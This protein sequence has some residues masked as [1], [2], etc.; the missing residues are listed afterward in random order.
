LIC[1][2]DV[3]WPSGSFERLVKKSIRNGFRVGWNVSLDEQR[4]RN[5]FDF[6]HFNL[7]L[8]FY[9][10]NF[11]FLLSQGGLVQTV[12]LLMKQRGMDLDSRDSRG[13]TALHLACKKGH[14]SAVQALLKLGADASASVS[15]LGVDENVVTCFHLIFVSFCQVVFGKEDENTFLAIDGRGSFCG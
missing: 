12:G 14:L 13:D 10:N 5:A 6:Y 2:P 15:R 11:V 1:S 8:L 9:F 4:A 7:L 3:N